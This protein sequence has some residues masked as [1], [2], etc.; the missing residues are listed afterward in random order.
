M[1]THLEG[2]Y[3]DRFPQSACVLGVHNTDGKQVLF[4]GDCP[5]ILDLWFELLDAGYT[6][7]EAFDLVEMVMGEGLVA[8]DPT[9]RNIVDKDTANIPNQIMDYGNHD[10]WK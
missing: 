10:L 3:L 9:W 4:S 7:D 8:T 1:A 2:N 6:K 5:E